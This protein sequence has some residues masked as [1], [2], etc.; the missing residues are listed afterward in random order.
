M[1]NDLHLVDYSRTVYRG[2]SQILLA[3]VTGD[4]DQFFEQVSLLLFPQSVKDLCEGENAV[5]MKNM[6]RFLISSTIRV[7]LVAHRILRQFLQSCRDLLPLFRSYQQIDVFDV[8]TASQEFFYQANTDETSA[9]S[10]ED[11]LAVIEVRHVRRHDSLRSSR[12]SDSICSPSR[13]ATRLKLTCTAFKSD[14]ESARVSG[15]L[16]QVNANYRYDRAAMARPI[17]SG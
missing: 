6:K 7:S 5:T 16:P 10:Q 2:Q 15:S 14:V 4:R 3:D 1:E 8:R 17:D 13:I 9:A 11:A 12:R